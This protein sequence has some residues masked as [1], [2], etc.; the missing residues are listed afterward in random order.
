M[1]DTLNDTRKSASGLY[2]LLRHKALAGT[3]M[4][5][6]LLGG[7]AV[8]GYT[9]SPWQAA[10]ADTAPIAVSRP[11]FADLAQKVSPAVVS[12]RVRENASAI[13]DSDDSFNGA[14][15]DLNQIP[16]QLRQFF[17]Q[18]PGEN[19]APEQAHPMALGSG[20]FISDDGYVVTNNHVVDHA[21][22][23]TVTTQDGSEYHAKLIGKDD[24]TDLALLKVTADKSAFPFVK[25]AQDPV[26]VGEWIMAVGNPYG[27]GGTVTA[28]IVSAT[29]R[30]IGSGP[31]DNYIQIDAPVNRGNS[32]GPTFDMNGEVI[33]INTAI[34]SPSGGSVGI[35]FDI[36]ASTAEHVITA[37]KDRGTVVRGWLGVE[38]QPVTRPLAESLQLDKAA[39]ALVTEPEANSPAAEAGIKSGDAILA[40]DGNTIKDPTDLAAK[41]ANYA[42]KSS[43][44]LSL[45]R[46][47]Q[48][49]DVTV[50]L[51]AMPGADQQAAADSGAKPASLS[52]LGLSVVPSDNGQGVVVAN[53]DPDGAAADSGINQ[54]DLI[55]SVGGAKIA[56]PAEV[57]KQIADARKDGLKAVLLRVQSGSET[58]YVG[59]SFAST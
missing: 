46:D 53:V 57:E 52:G 4:T 18:M 16:P 39:G 3:A 22:N 28:G 45:W 2:R 32:G 25:F 40:V 50:E 20:F 14:L 5:L 59:V 6:L 44:T 58:H 15:P 47:G 54:G 29:G 17:Q 13:A 23:F 48:K 56:S 36:P 34:Y 8:G 10:R 27:L 19:A 51:G 49:K 31:Y 37:L 38:I 24:K 42:P 1:T 43:V 26:R 35:A 33:G 7:A 21:T 55:V 41:I 12:I 30:N 9:M 11:D